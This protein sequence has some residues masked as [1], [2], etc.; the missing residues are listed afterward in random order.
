MEVDNGIEEQRRSK[1]EAT[2]PQDRTPGL[3]TRNFIFGGTGT[4]QRN[5]TASV[6]AL[7]FF[8][9]GAGWLG[10]EPVEFP[11]NGGQEVPA[12][13]TDRMGN[14]E[15]YLD[16]SETEYDISCLHD[17]TEVFGAHIHN[18]AAGENGPIVFFFDAATTFSGVVSSSSLEEQ[19]EMFSGSI[20][21]VS[22]EEFLWLLRTGSLYVNVHS[23]A[24]PSGEIRGQI[25]PPPSLFFSQFG[26]GEAGGLTVTSDIVLLNS[27]STGDPITAIVNL[28][29]PD[30]NPLDV[31][32]EGGSNQATIEP[33]RSATF[34]T[35]GMGDLVVGSASVTANGPV[36]GVIK[37][38][39]PGFGV[40]GVQSSKPLT[41]FLVPVR[42]E[43]TIRTALAIRN[44]SRI[45]IWV[46]L[47]AWVFVGGESVHL[48]AEIHLGVG[49]GS[50]R[51]VDEIFPELDGQEFSG[52]VTAQVDDGHMA[53]IALEQ[54][55]GVFTTLPVTPPV[56]PLQ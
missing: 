52:T 12:E 32:F 53:A 18:G 2:A 44:T 42:N 46:T 22:F 29:D 48:E 50:A 49:A 25:L 38:G 56:T 34:R 7:L 15:A 3:Q 40:A 55:P 28:L 8:L 1:R 45:E 37:F 35:D 47:E 51:F 4:M 39:I 43:G 19:A 23:P 16:L 21:P 27:A 17:V 36:A 30:G 6:I 26:N 10:A 41:A 54:G 33:S 13:T 11:L 9:L 5:R 20:E 31:A 14:C 24:V